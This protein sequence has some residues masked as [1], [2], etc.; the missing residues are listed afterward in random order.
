MVKHHN[1]YQEDYDKQLEK[2]KI[3]INNIE[4]KLDLLKIKKEFYEK[5]FTEIKKC[6][7]RQSK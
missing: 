5:A 7:A 4:K 2:L 1:K 6:I 3:K